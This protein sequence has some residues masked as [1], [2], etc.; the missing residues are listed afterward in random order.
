M[1]HLIHWISILDQTN[2]FLSDR[3]TVPSKQTTRSKLTRI[4]IAKEKEKAKYVKINE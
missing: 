2:V 3:K 1:L 4:E